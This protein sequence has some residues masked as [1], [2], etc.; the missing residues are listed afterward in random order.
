MHDQQ[1]ARVGEPAA[2]A[3][4]SVP[5][6]VASAARSTR[7]DG[8]RPSGQARVV[9][10]RPAAAPAAPAAQGPRAQEAP[11]RARARRRGRGSGNDYGHAPSRRGRPV[12]SRRDA[13]ARE[14]VAGL[15]RTPASRAPRSVAAT[16]FEQRD[17]TAL[18]M[19][20][21]YV[22]EG[23]HD[24]RV[25]L[26]LPGHTSRIEDYDALVPALARRYRAPLPDL[27]GKGHRQACAP[28]QPRVLRGDHRRLPHVL[29]V[30]R[31][32][33]IGGNLG[34]NLAPRLADRY[35]GAS[36]V[37]G[38]AGRWAAP[39]GRDWLGR[40]IGLAER[41]YRL[42]R[43]AAH[44]VQPTA[45]ATATPAARRRCATSRAPR[46][47]DGTGFAAMTSG[48]PLTGRPR[49]LSRS[50][51]R[52]A[53]RTLSSS[54]TSTPAP[55][56]S[57]GTAASRSPMPDAEAL[58]IFPNAIR[59]RPSP[60]SADVI[61]EVPGSGVRSPSIHDIEP[62]RAGGSLQSL[63][64]PRGEA[65]GAL[66]SSSSVR[67]SASC[68]PPGPSSLDVSVWFEETWPRCSSSCAKSW[69]CSVYRPSGAAHCAPGLL[70]LGDEPN[71]GVTF[72]RWTPH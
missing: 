43:R 60:G 24:A 44:S 18:G 54:A 3:A 51:P 6:A 1:R 41:S 40:V 7:G 72:E 58:R 20:L 46:R 23:P 16:P 21:R 19:R 50:C 66:G 11:A 68:L 13:G 10:G 61:L 35:P 49:S 8:V 63:A 47:G 2:R 42:P 69:V 4:K 36:S 28:L 56:C 38:R 15:P 52:S 32:D 37:L 62:G 39:G 55:T 9:T 5:I 27:P 29:G 71:R 31:L 14:L 64:L 53:N 59:R 30:A 26:V 45:T 67:C 22:D 17:L 34:A 12:R 33:V 70:A 65:V 48:W 57:A 25:A